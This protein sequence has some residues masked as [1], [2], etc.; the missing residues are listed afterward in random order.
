M[1]TITLPN[2]VLECYAGQGVKEPL[3]KI[4]GLWLLEFGFKAD[5]EITMVI[6]D[7][8]ISILNTACITNNNV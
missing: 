6:E 3:I 5:M 2:K 1:N 7:A 4:Q 8:K